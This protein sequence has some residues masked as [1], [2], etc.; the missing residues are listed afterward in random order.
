MNNPHLSGLELYLRAAQ[1]EL[2]AFDML[3]LLEL[4]KMQLKERAMALYHE[5]AL[6][7][8]ERR[9]RGDTPDHVHLTYL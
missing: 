1:T 9:K 5:S 8:Y 3:E 2:I 4:L 7:E 6:D